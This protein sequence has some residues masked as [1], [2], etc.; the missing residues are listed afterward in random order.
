MTFF[1]FQVFQDI[2]D[3]YLI[4]CDLISR[5]RFLGRGA[6]GAVYAGTLKNKVRACAQNNLS[7]FASLV[8]STAQGF[9]S[10]L[11]D[12][13]RVM[14]DVMSCCQDT[15][16]DVAV[17]IKMMQPVDPGDDAS[18]S[19]RMQYLV[20]LRHCHCIYRLVHQALHSFRLGIPYVCTCTRLYMTVQYNQYRKWDFPFIISVVGNGQVILSFCGTAQRLI[21]I[22]TLSNG[23]EC[24]TCWLL[25]YMYM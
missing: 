2:G 9:I 12:L 22:H 20:R 1:S 25:M 5:G 3:E 13:L 24:L 14:S 23:N 17:A 8:N 15:D 18:D 16:D 4:S 11:I 19:L 7:D 10:W 21:S 6:F